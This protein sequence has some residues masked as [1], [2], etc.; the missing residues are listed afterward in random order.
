ML[1]SLYFV[2]STFCWHS[3]RVL[4]RVPDCTSNL[5][6][7]DILKSFRY[8]EFKL[9]KLLLCCLIARAPLLLP[10]ACS[11]SHKHDDGLQ[12]GCCKCDLHIFERLLF[13]TYS[14]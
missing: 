6:A 7:W 5:Q 4:E 14:A 9:L 11:G 8:R 10:A 3:L 1:E 12:T 2:L 13:E